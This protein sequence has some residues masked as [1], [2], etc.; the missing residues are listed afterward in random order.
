MFV[1]TFVV[2]LFSVI[3]L[4]H[5]GYF[6]MH[7]D[8]QV[9]RLFE[10]QKCFAVGQ[11]P[12]RWATDMAFGYGQPLFNFYSA[13]PYYLG[14]F[15]HNLFQISLIDTAKILFAISLVASA[16]GMYFLAKEF[17]GKWGAFLASVLYLY[18]PYHSVD[19]Y[20]RGA[21]AE[22]FSLAILPFLWLVIYKAIKKPSFKYV[23]L[24]S[25]AVAAQ[26]TTHNVSTM[27]YSVF[28]GIWA[29]FWL[30]KEM[31]LKSLWSVAA[32][33][34]LGLGLSGFF[35]LPVI[36]EKSLIQD[37]FFTTDYLYYGAHFASFR[38][39]FFSRF[40]GYG[41]SV[42]GDHDLMSFQVGWPHWW[43]LPVIALA[44]LWFIRKKEK[45]TGFLVLGLAVLSVFAIFLTHERSTPI[46]VAFP[47]L[48]F[49]QFPW[50]FLGVAIFLLSFAAGIL[51]KIKNKPLRLFLV[52]VPAVLAFALNVGYFHPHLYFETDTDQS[53]LSGEQFIIQ[54]K[55][56]ILDYLPKTA[57]DAP[58]SLAPDKPWLVSG[59]AELP[60]FT[61]TASTFFFDAKVHD[62][63]VIQ[64]P[65]MYFPGW[66]VYSLSGQ[67]I[68]LPV[69][70]G[71]QYGAMQITLPK[72]DYMIEGRFT[73]T[74]IRSV[75]NALTVISFFALLGGTILN[76]NKKRVLGLS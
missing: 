17:F 21:L 11:I 71:G 32:G 63:A 36:F 44:A 24:L 22:A 27:M 25:L 68:E 33:G 76:L 8:L 41:G 53:K 67:G 56:A 65:I 60:N 16:V 62:D 54:Q 14:S 64:I 55:S 51:A 2:S 50:R 57:K 3:P 23:A 20:V 4:L 37:Q 73:N 42:F 49:V 18:A 28:S 59:E 19:V 9:M 40:W 30:V 12:C 43:L 7:D 52:L 74:P 72:G 45:T 10:M 75:G 34:I 31:N 58:K 29:L 70:V 35:I 39:L 38:Q 6:P 69:E 1:V 15:I 47:P 13:F 5:K 46:W 61:K 26:L 66:K 48:A